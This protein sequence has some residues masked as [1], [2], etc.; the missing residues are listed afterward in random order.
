M[1]ISKN[2]ILV[3]SSVLIVALLAG[4]AGHNVLADTPNIEGDVAGFFSGLWH[5]III[6]FSFIG[7]LFSDNIS[8]YEVHNNGGWY[9]FGYLIGICFFGVPIIAGIIGD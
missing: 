5:G 2:A 7:S 6:F 9:N 8:M 3:A 4:C 1:R